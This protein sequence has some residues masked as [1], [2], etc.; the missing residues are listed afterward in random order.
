MLDLTEAQTNAFFTNSIY[1]NVNE[2]ESRIGVLFAGGAFAIRKRS[3][4]KIGGFDESF[5]GWGGEDD[6]FTVKMD[7]L[8]R[9]LTLKDN[10]SYHLYHDRLFTGT[11]NHIHYG[12]NVNL[13][14][15]IKDMG[16]DELVSYCVSIRGKFNEMYGGSL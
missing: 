1:P 3:F 4:C 9:Y 5:I 7:K 13:V 16:Y 11:A 6:A 2:C 10:V 12:N 14:A 8:C 15:K